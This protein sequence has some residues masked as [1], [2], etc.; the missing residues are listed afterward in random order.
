MKIKIIFILAVS[1]FLCAVSYARIGVGEVTLVSGETKRFKVQDPR[2]VVISNPEVVDVLAVT[3]G[4]IVLTAR[5]A[6]STDFIFWD[7]S[8]ENV[9]KIMVFPLKIDEL[10]LKVINMLKVLGL[11]NVYTK[12]IK[13]DGR[14]L[15]LGRV[16]SIEDKEKLRNALGQ[17][18]NHVT[19]IINV[20]EEHLIEI[21]VEVMEL[22]QDA[23]KELGIRWPSGA[24]LTE[25]GA[26]RTVAN[27]PDAI[28]GFSDW[29]R[30]NFTATLSFLVS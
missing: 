15:L 5:A 8:G 3:A 30:N 21:A 14:V 7:K 23:S 12:P 11:D 1:V 19:D 20:E 17:L 10:N 26:V 4:E 2:R 29:T 25:P 28:F 6:G 16:R 24:A 18:W 22:T 9:F 13:E 27:I